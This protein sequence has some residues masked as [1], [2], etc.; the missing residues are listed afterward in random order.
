[1][2]GTSKTK[3]DEQNR[4]HSVLTKRGDLEASQRLT[5]RLYA[6]Y[7]ENQILIPN[8]VQFE[9]EPQLI[10]DKQRQEYDGRHRQTGRDQN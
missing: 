5:Q 9:K 10:V 2:E 7:S 1:M 4:T 8:E 6:C 3:E